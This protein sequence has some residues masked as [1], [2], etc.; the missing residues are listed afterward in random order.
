M[1]GTETVAGLAVTEPVAGP[2]TL[3]VYPGADGRCSVY[4][5]DGISFAYRRGEWMGIEITWADASRSVTL[6]LAPG[7]RMLPPDRRP[8]EVRVAGETR[9]QR[10]VFT[11]VPLTV[12]F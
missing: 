12:R 1:K 2:L 7:S 3:V 11:G 5:D 6:R 10:V 9:S 8:I 4:E